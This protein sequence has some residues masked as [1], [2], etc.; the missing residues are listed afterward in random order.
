MS[1]TPLDAD[2]LVVGAGVAGLTTALKLLTQ[3]PDRKVVVLEKYGKLGGR[4][5]TFKKD[6][7]GVA[8]VQWENGAGRIHAS[9]KRLLSAL[10]HY[11]LH[12]APISPDAEFRR[13][14]HRGCTK[15]TADHFEELLQTFITPLQALSRQ[16]LGS[17]TLLQVANEIHGPER[18][19]ALFD[20]FPYYTEVHNL[21]A[22]L[23]LKTFAAEM[24]TREA[25]SVLIEGFSALIDALAADIRTRGGH[26]R[27]RHTL[28]S[29]RE[30]YDDDG[31]FSHIEAS[32][33]IYNPET[34]QTSQHTLNV[35][36]LILAL[37]AEALR[38]LKP[39]RAWTPLKYLGSAP[40]VRIYAVFP[41]GKN[42]RVWFDGMPRT[43][44]TNTLR[45][46]IPINPD[47]GIIMISYT[48]GLD[49]RPWFKLADSGSPE[50]AEA[51]QKKLMHEVR[52]TFG[53]DVPE[54]LY[55]KAH[56]WTV[57]TTYWKPGT[58]DVTAMSRAAHK[59]SPH[60]FVTG[61]AIS[62]NQAWI[63][64]ALESVETLFELPE[65]K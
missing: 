9:H 38:K 60:V 1:N 23:A 44:T 32:V 45:Y 15:P 12:T 58:Y 59:V 18:T 63:E 62:L 4:A 43:I 42:G 33:E 48:D 37:H 64:G 47:K 61:E 22:D 51:L 21:R 27:P 29:Y 53:P 46:V 24:G 28:K 65:F 10:K 54:P 25:Y 11:D 52:R 16:T 56:P 36:R 55:L 35:R 13:C 39:L 8:H 2:T 49:T 3:H 30:H 6:I 19:K 57:G 50:N 41:K 7:P 40:L 26:I 5:M 17:H 34:K 20:Q 31:K 14:N